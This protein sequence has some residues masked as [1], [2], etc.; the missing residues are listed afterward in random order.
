MENLIFCIDQADRLERKL[1]L[2]EH[3]YLKILWRYHEDAKTGCKW[4]HKTLEDVCFPLGHACQREAGISEID[5]KSH[6]EFAV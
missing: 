2:M 1:I 3:L 5:V 4:C 6:M